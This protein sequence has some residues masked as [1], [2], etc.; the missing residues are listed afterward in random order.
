[1]GLSVVRSRLRWTRDRSVAAIRATTRGYQRDEVA[2]ALAALLPAPGPVV[3]WRH[4]ALALLPFVDDPAAARVAVQMQ[5]ELPDFEV[6][7]D[8]LDAR[9]LF[10]ATG[11][12]LRSAI[13]AA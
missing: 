1:M 13:A 2:A 6:H 9:D 10:S 12:D 4:G 8:R 7:S 3:P 11:R 5:A